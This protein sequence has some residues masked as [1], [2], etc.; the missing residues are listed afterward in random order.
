MHGKIERKIRH[1]KESFSKHLF[2]ERLSVI[3]WETL[4]DQIPNSIN[5]LPIAIGNVTQDLENL[6]LTPNRLILARNNDRCPVCM[7]II[8][9]DVRKII[10]QNNDMVATWLKCWL[11]SYVP[12]LMMQPKWFHSDRDPKV[13]DIILF[14]K[15]EKEFAKKNQYGII[16]DLTVGR[17]GKIRNLQ[18][19]YR[20]HN[21]QTKRCTNRGTREV[22]VIHPID[23]L[24]P[25]REINRLA[26]GI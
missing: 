23:E 10:Q 6:D 19:E 5:N 17:D 15:S 7:L 9:E 8:M 20:N 1:V 3:Q 22:V 11:I 13:G 18:V 26:N 2:K 14:L 12:T 21:E 25:M 16:C 4:G 24:G